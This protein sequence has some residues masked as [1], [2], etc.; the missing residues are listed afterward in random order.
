M[1]TAFWLGCF[2]ARCALVYLAHRNR[3]RPSSVVPIA[4]LALLVGIGFIVL[5]VKPELRPVAAE[6]SAG[7]H[8]VWWADRRWIHGVL[9]LAFALLFAL[10]STRHLAWVCLA[11]DVALGARFAYTHGKG[12]R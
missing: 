6:S 11:I 8:V 1:S 3:T 7:G 12:R 4:G 5:A 10:P 2:P 9:F